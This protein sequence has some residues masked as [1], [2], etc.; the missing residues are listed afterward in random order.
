MKDRHKAKGYHYRLDP[1]LQR[2]FEA[3]LEKTGQTQY[4][5]I[6]RLIAQEIYNTKGQNQ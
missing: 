3:Y 6:K 2:D 5:V 4:Q 1:D